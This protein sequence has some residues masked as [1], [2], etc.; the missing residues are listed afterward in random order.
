MKLHIDFDNKTIE[1]LE[2]CTIDE[3]N[4]VIAKSGWTEYKIIPY[5]P[6]NYK[7]TTYPPLIDLSKGPY[8]YGVDPY[9]IDNRLHA[10]WM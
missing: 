9:T 2:E 8:C 4:S 7:I 3:L 5:Q 6:L 10:G 1:I